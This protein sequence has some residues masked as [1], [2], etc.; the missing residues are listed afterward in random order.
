MPVITDTA[1]P[2]L[3]SSPSDGELDVFTPSDEEISFALRHTRQ[4]GPRLALLIFLK[5]FQRLG[6]FVQIA[7]VPEAII[8]HIA[9]AAKLAGVMA[10]VADYDDTTYRTR[11]MQLVR[12][13]A[14]VSGYDR[15]ARGIAARATMAA[16]RTRDDLPDLVNVAIEE[17]VRK[18]YELPTGGF[19]K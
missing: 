8:A 18:R 16:A 11:L 1:Y 15:T 3:T 9:E 6:Y 2:R 12:N 10:G 7:D 17:L 14:G 5:T 4:P 13:F 19:P